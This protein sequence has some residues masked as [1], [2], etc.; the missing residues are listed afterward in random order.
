MFTRTHLTHK[1][2]FGNFGYISPKKMPVLGKYIS[3]EFV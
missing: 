1:S 2:N 3:F